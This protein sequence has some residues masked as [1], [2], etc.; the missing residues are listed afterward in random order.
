MVM[1]PKSWSTKTCH[2]R[3]WQRA[4]NG[5]AS[6]TVLVRIGQCSK[7]GTLVSFVNCVHKLMYPVAVCRLPNG[8]MF[9]YAQPIPASWNWLLLLLASMAGI[10][11]LLIRGTLL[12]DYLRE[13][14]LFLRHNDLLGVGGWKGSRHLKNCPILL[15]TPV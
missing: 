10:S 15:P 9:C 2:L 12:G 1:V 7:D 6:R 4:D 5:I 8:K 14:L 3:Q 13:E 11:I